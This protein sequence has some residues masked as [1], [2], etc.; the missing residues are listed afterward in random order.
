MLL[1]KANGEI[2][3]QEK[4]VHGLGATS[5]FIAVALLAVLLLGPS[6][7][8]E[9]SSQFSPATAQNLNRT[10]DEF[11]AQN[12]VPGIIVGIWD[13]LR[14]EY[15]AARGLAVVDP[16]RKINDSDLVR[17]GSITK[18][19]TATVVLQLVEEKRLSLNDNLD[20]YYPEVPNASQITIRMLL[21]H[22]SG[23]PE[24]M[25]NTILQEELIKDPS[26]RWNLTELIDMETRGAALHPP[27][28][29][30]HY[31]NLNYQLL[32]GIIE[33]VT[34]NPLAEE[35]SLRLFLPLGLN[36]TYYPDG[37]EMPGEYAH[38]YIQTGGVQYD[39]TS[40]LDP[41]VAGAA[42]AIISN[43]YDMKVWAR[44]VG[45]GELLSQELQRERLQWASPN[46]TEEGVL[47][48][49]LGIVY[50]HGFIG[51]HGGFNGYQSSA[52]YLPDK[53]AVI[54]MF[55]N[56]MNTTTDSNELFRALAREAF[57]KEYKT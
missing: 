38:G 41:S 36:H 10:V 21:A 52:M 15:I 6:S 13:P 44:A 3:T 50:D 1:I 9:G 12:N 11:M 49:G 33:Q 42:G 31:S 18:E 24:H 2:M 20:K 26:K 25:N 45:R 37:A 29:D 22:T 53:D 4:N 30:F 5:G 16:P 57:P 46:K 54:V 55:L 8:A 43:L 23:L 40:A 7:Y 35:F 19:F 27:G 48:I 47:M 32:G 14:G 28:S 34:G 56:E 17:I 39:V 51:F